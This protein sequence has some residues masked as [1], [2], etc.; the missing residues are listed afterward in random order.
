MITGGLHKHKY[1]QL[2]Y[3]SIDY[4]RKASNACSDDREMKD[5]NLW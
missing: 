5:D 1:F 4:N 2:I 3:G